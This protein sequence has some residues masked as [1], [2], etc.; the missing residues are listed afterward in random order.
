VDITELQGLAD[1]TVYGILQDAEGFL[2]VSTNNGLSRFNPS[3]GQFMNFSVKEGLGSNEFNLGA[4]CIGRDGKL[5]FGGH[6]GFVGFVPSLGTNPVPP[7]LVLESVH[8]FGKSLYGLSAESIPHALEF[9][10][11]ARFFSFQ[12]AALHYKDPAKNL[13]SFKIEGLDTAWSQPSTYRMVD[14][15]SIPSGIYSLRARSANCDGV[16]DMDGVVIPIIVRA[17]YWG[18]WWFAASTL[19]FLTFVA[20]ISYRI[21]FRRDLAEERKA[22]KGQEVLRKKLAADFHDELGAHAAKIAFSANLLHANTNERFSKQDEHLSQIAWH[23][24]LLMKEMREMAWQLD[25]QKDSLMDLAVH[26]KDFSEEL[27]ESTQIAFRTVGL[28]ASFENL[29]LPMEWRQ[30]LLRIFKEAMTNVIKH[31]TGSRNVS[32]SFLVVDRSLRM[33]LSDDGNGFSPLAASQGNGLKNMEFRADQIGG[34]LTITS[35]KGAG[36]N[37][38]FEGQLP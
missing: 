31:A 20:G 34:V 6:K 12:F 28:T 5:Y 16:W 30:Q 4:Q 2:W 7:H 33:E 13:Y 11:D 15:A 35:T 32:L 26:L 8:A 19:A 1:N 37:V 14:Y 21:K 23:A 38:R 9:S 3:N 17:P 22:Q 25:P 29:A 27:F 36:T 18:T 10:H 24:S